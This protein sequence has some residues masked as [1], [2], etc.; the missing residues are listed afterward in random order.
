[1]LQSHFPVYWYYI[2]YTY[3]YTNFY[4]CIIVI[5]IEISH[6]KHNI[7]EYKNKIQNNSI[8]KYP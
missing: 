6:S 5:H 7:G 8:T 4:V 2:Q 1:M 3:M